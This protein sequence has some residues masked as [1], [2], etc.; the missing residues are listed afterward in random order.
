MS[1]KEL[2]CHGI[3]ID[4]LLYP[5]FDEIIPMG[6]KTLYSC[7][8][9]DIIDGYISFVTI[10]DMLVFLKLINNQYTSLRIIY[11]NNREY[12]N[13]DELYN[14]QNDYHIRCAVEF[15]TINILKYFK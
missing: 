2:R 4:E 15:K 5:I 8:G 7:Q 10:K 14:K 13:Y 3:Y 11:D 1:H 12:V 6:L 9:D